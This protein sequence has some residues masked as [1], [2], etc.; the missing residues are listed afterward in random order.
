MVRVVAKCSTII[1]NPK[2]GKHMPSKCYRKHISVLGEVIK[3]GKKKKTKERKKE[4][5]SSS[6]ESRNES[7]V[8]KAARPTNA[9]KKA[10]AMALQV[11]HLFLQ[12]LNA[13]INGIHSRLNLLHEEGSGNLM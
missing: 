1:T 13:C 5:A 11:C 2:C 6:T 10:L 12:S 4:T 3:E 8:S 9:R 7:L